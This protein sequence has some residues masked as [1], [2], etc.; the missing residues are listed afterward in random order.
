MFNA[1]SKIEMNENDVF[2][3]LGNEND[4]GIFS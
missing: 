1:H 2:I 3:I 4:L